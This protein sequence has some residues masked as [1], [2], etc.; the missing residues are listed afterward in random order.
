ML[1]D[2]SLVFALI[3]ARGGSKGVRRKNLT[4]LAG[5]PLIAHTISAA[6]NSLLIDSICVSSDDDEILNISESLE[7]MPLRRPMEYASDYA[8]A[9]DVISHY[10]GALPTDVSQKNNIILYLQPTS[11]LR[12][13]MHIDS[14]LSAMDM[15]KANGVISVVEAEMPP[16]KSFRLDENGRLISLFDERQSNERRQDLPRCYYPNGAIYAFR[17]AEFIA[18]KGLPS[19]GSIPYIMSS[20]DSIDIDNVTDLM[21]AESVIGERNGRV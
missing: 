19:N 1:S 16:Q 4:N 17:I 2:G 20:I 14:A 11:P 3:P 21:L 8:S 10:I 6:K 7:V 9:N 13:E 18:R 5:K 12:N 15:A